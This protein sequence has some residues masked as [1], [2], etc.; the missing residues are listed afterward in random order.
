ML[1]NY[2]ISI[3]S[4][5]ALSLFFICCYSSCICHGAYVFALNL[6]FSEPSINSHDEYRSL[7]SKSTA[8]TVRILGSTEPGCLLEE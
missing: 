6:F 8:A 3:L 2:E 5:F 4:T 7:G 1:I